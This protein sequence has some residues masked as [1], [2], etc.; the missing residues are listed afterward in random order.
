M[1]YRQEATVH[2]VVLSVADV[3]R[4]C[5]FYSGVLGFRLQFR[6]GDRWAQ[7]SAGDVT[8]AVA[9]P[10]EAEPGTTGLA[11]KVSDVAA[12]VDAVVAAGGRVLRPPAAGSHELR[13]TVADPAGLIVYVFQPMPG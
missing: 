3:S 6:D 8:L 11:L 2:S 10:G 4:A 1:P 12:T 13:A 7:L 5:G 9:G